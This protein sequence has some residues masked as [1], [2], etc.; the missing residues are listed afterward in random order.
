MTV[1]AFDMGTIVAC[2]SLGSPTDGCGTIWGCFIRWG[3]GATILFVAEVSTIIASCWV[4]GLVFP[5]V[6]TRGNWAFSPMDWTGTAVWRWLMWAC[7]LFKR[8]ED[9]LPYVI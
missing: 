8:S 7:N 3:F 5:P 2:W 9:D 1:P 6:T 4:W